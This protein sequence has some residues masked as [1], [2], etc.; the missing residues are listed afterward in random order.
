MN[1]REEDRSVEVDGATLAGTLTVPD[2][3]GP[4]PMTLL[5]GGT[6]SDLRDADV[7]P[8]RREGVPKRG[9]YKILAHGLA[10]VGIASY[11]FDR[12]GAGESTG[13]FGVERAQEVADAGAVWRWVRALPECN[14]KAAMLGHSAGAYV[15]C[16][17]ALEVGQPDA[18]VLQGALYRSIAELLR[19]NYS[20]VLD[21]IQ[22]GEEQAAWVRDHCPKAYEDALMMDALVAAI[23]GGDAIVEAE[24]DGE[25]ITRDLSSLRYDLDLPPEDQF[26]LLTAPTL[27]L[28]SSEDLNVPVEDAFDTVAALWAAGNRD[29]ELRILPGGNHSFQ[30]DAED[31]ET[32]VQEKITMENFARPFDP[33]YPA[34]VIDYLARRLT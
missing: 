17:V 23:E 18:A 6:F 27:V 25:P 32:R 28:H 1:F 2:T 4:W 10:E 20:L 8:K 29:V 26:R 19:Y 30:F 31:Y 12:R 5:L 33:L 14:G 9:M 22:L 21:Y 7:D 3:D 15:L 16:R 34:V 13:E 11:R 24:V